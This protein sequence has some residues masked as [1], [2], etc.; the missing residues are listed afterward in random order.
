MSFKETLHSQFTPT[1]KFQLCTV[2]FFI[3]IGT[4]ILIR[5]NPHHKQY[6]QGIYC[7]ELNSYS[8]NKYCMYSW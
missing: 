7:L 1:C 5:T 3:K 6:K 2:F 4:N 8:F